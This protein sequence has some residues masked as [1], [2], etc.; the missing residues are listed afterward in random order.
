MASG[1][2]QIPV[3]LR[4]MIAEFLPQADKLNFMVTSRALN[5]PGKTALYRY[6]SIISFGC[7]NPGV[8]GLEPCC[9]RLKDFIERAEVASTNATRILP[10]QL[11]FSTRAII[12][13]PGAHANRNLTNDAA[14]MARFVQYLTDTATIF[15]TRYAPPPSPVVFPGDWP[16]QL[17]IGNYYAFQILELQIRGPMLLALSFESIVPDPRATDCLQWMDQ[18]IGVNLP[19]GQ[20]QNLVLTSLRSIEVRTT[21]NQSGPLSIDY[22]GDV[23]LFPRLE[24][25]SYSYGVPT[26]TTPANN[27]RELYLNKFG[28]RHQSN[29][30]FPGTHGQLPN[31]VPNALPHQLPQLN[32]QN[33]LHLLS[34]HNLTMAL[35]N[36]PQLRILEL[37]ETRLCDG[38]LAGYPFHDL[39]T[40]AVSVTTPLG[41]TIRRFLPNLRSFKLKSMLY[42]DQHGPNVGWW[43]FSEYF[44]NLGDFAPLNNLEHLDLDCWFFFLGPL[45]TLINNPPVH[46]IDIGRSI[47]TVRISNL[48]HGYCRQFYDWLM[49]V[50]V[51]KLANNLPN[52]RSIHYSVLP[53]AYGGSG[54]MTAGIPTLVWTQLVARMA[55]AGISLAHYT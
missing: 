22:W 49:L 5:G 18:D 1:L 53:P 34:H 48:T 3:E 35:Q 10:K 19:A 39:A 14:F 31:Q 44:F 8:G 46:A 17:L 55:N 20:Q 47:E 26:N 51:N 29:T 27:I 54:L 6:P 25:V 15:P 13:E 4:T 28:C 52:L 40:G 2:E 9:T 50:E 33:V 7:T 43:L 24:R 23:G 37:N 38:M 30:T 41:N 21:N 32:G 42:N 11:T 36:M 12:L 45:N 16:Y